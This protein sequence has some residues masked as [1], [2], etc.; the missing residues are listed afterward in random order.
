[1][2]RFALFPV[3]LLLFAFFD[4]AA[5]ATEGPVALCDPAAQQALSS[6]QEEQARAS[7]EDGLA[8][9]T[10]AADVAEQASCTFYLGLTAQL[11]AARPATDRNKLLRQASDWY[12]SSLKVG[13]PSPGLI[14]NLAR[15][16]ADL[17]RWDE[18]EAL[19]NEAI[20]K[21]Q[22]RLRQNLT[23]SFADL[24]AAS[25]HS[26]PRAVEAY[27]ELLAQMPAD[28]PTWE[29]LLGLLYRRQPVALP[30]VV[31]LAV[32]ASQTVTAQRFAFD[33]LTRA[34]LPADARSS[35]LAAIVAALARQYDDVSALL[36]SVQ[37][38]RL[39]ALRQDPVVGAGAAQV[40][41]LGSSAKL[42][43]EDFTWW[44]GRSLSYPRSR[45]GAFRAL[46]RAVA[47]SSTVQA[48]RPTRAYLELAEQL[49]SD[50]PDAGVYRDLLASYA[51]SDQVDL[52][53]RSVIKW[54]AVLAQATP[55]LPAQDTARF[56]LTASRLLRLVHHVAPSGA[57][58]DA[59]FQLDRATKDASRAGDPDL[60]EM[61]QI[62]ATE[63]RLGEV[64]KTAQEALQRAMEA[65]KLAEGMFLFETVLTDD[66]VKF[67]FNKSQLSLQAKAAL[68]EFADKVKADNTAVFI[69][70]QGHTDNIGSAHY[71]LELAAARAEAVVSYLNEKGLSVH[72]MNAISYG[73]TA[74]VA[75]NKTRLGRA[76]NRRVALVVLQ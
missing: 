9:A 43:P 24:I 7:F 72:R 34:D 65:G 71:N 39:D 76:K 50:T 13:G 60:I 21:A 25:D 31:W 49:D 6:G 15:V 2:W 19:Y 10:A 47:R 57:P 73:E 66:K 20:E 26:W 4:R 54:E 52:V 32:E 37:A 48:L 53:A 38:G 1:M 46:L 69:E 58:D 68:D 27:R 62:A 5:L 63:Q 36:S 67:G 61:A 35:L 45:L 11:E 44:T 17:G 22:G 42:S 16:K 18:A 3:L 74:P 28:T 30:D 23:R 14:M 41:A 12:Q 40:L 51:A 33:S 55:Q 56:H 64:S 8:R 59:H 70:V 29:A 75:D